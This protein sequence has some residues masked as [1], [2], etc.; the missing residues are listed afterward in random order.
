MKRIVRFLKAVWFVYK[1]GS[2]EIEEMRKRAL[3]DYLTGV[4]NKWCLFEI[5]I[6]EVERAKRY[7]YPLSLILVDIDGLKLINDKEG[8]LKGD[9]VI[10]KVAKLLEI[11][12]RKSDL[13]FRFGG[14][15]F[16]I[17]CPNTKKEGCNKIVKRIKNEAKKQKIGLSCGVAEYSNI[18]EVE[19]SEKI[20]KKMI[21]F[22]DCKMYEDKENKK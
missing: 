3:Y 17:L 2:K 16:I 22:A 6:R 1:T 13:V 5:G 11:S 9:E 15:E 10:K 20:L 18:N 19:I 12:C 7:R 14:D 4:Y 21:M 8:H